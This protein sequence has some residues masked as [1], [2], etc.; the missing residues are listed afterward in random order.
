[1]ADAKLQETYETRRFPLYERSEMTTISHLTGSETLEGH[2]QFFQ[3]MIP[4]ISKNTATGDAIINIEKRQGMKLYEDLITKSGLA[5][6]INPLDM[7]AINQLSDTLVIAFYRNNAGTKTIE[8]AA[9]R[10]TAGT[11]TLIGTIA[12]V[13]GPPA[14]TVNETTDIYLTEIK[15]GLVPGVAVMMTNASGASGTSAGYYALSSSGV[16]GV[17]T[18]TKIADADFPTNQTPYLHIVGAMQQMNE[19]C[20][21]QTSDGRIWNSN[22]DSIGVWSALGFLE[23]ESYADKGVGLMRFK[24]HIVAFGENSIEFFD[25]VGNDP[26]LGSPLERTEQAFIKFGAWYGKSIIN[27]DDNL[28]WVG[29]S[30]SS[31]NGIWKLDG[32]SPVEISTRETNAILEL[33]KLSVPFGNPEFKRNLQVQQVIF[34]GIKNI[35]ITASVT[36]SFIR[37]G[38]NGFTYET[39]EMIIF[40]GSYYQIC[41]V[42]YNIKDQLWWHF[43]YG[44]NKGATATFDLSGSVFSFIFASLESSQYG[45]VTVI[46]NYTGFATPTNEQRTLLW[47]DSFNVGDI[48]FNDYTY[49][50]HNAP[51]VSSWN[52]TLI[53][54]DTDKRKFFHKYKL[55]PGSWIYHNDSVLPTQDEWIKLI[56]RKEFI[57]GGNFNSTIC[58]N[59]K[60]PNATNSTSLTR[61][62]GN[63]LGLFRTAQ[64]GM[65]YFGY[66]PLALQAWEGDFSQG[67]F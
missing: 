50:N 9:Y 4:F 14:V 61:Y 10:P 18:L 48:F 40:D 6:T 36:N 31:T 56:V 38:F 52:S 44:S 49:L 30:N 53:S 26:T 19:I 46:G 24:H 27:C 22:T 41:G 65:I 34:N 12:T 8:I 45:L 25:D 64:V 43:N 15:I 16:F 17:G 55:I 37:N 11:F 66:A 23:A 2:N 20:Y 42:M 5:G 63:N 54:F 28:Y 58:R 21:I 47:W 57:G 33:T 1:M 39:G 7:L 3:N 59:V 13:A 32:Y 29:Y 35:Y 62:Y 67:T 60:L 51:I